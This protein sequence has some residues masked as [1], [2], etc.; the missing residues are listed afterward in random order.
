MGYS[1]GVPQNETNCAA[2]AHSW[3]VGQHYNYC[4]RCGLVQTTDPYYK[5][6]RTRSR[7][8]AMDTIGKAPLGK[9]KP[10][11]V[12]TLRERVA[13]RDGNECWWCIMPG[14]KDDPLTLEHVPRLARGGSWKLEDLR[15]AHRSCNHDRPVLDKLEEA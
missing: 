4:Q 6:K 13:R 7:T 11:K 2:G 1:V 14:T 15:L 10:S 12:Q 8:Y 5:T 9:R 3:K